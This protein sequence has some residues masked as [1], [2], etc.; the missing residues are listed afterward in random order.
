MILPSKERQRRHWVSRYHKVLWEGV[1]FNVSPD[2]P[3]RPWGVRILPYQTGDEARVRVEI[4]QRSGGQAP[5]AFQLVL[6]PPSNTNLGDD[7]LKQCAFDAGT[8]PIFHFRSHTMDA[9][10]EY[11]LYIVFWPKD[12][13]GRLQNAGKE[14]AA[15]IQVRTNLAILGALWTAI[16]GAAA[17]GGTLLIQWLTRR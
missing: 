7:L 15:T 8:R 2:G 13:D 11:R 9:S 10:G 17:V 6:V 5:D 3:R 14:L 1:Q 4:K 12:K 16:V